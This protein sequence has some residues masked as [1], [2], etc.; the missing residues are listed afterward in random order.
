L[1]GGYGSFYDRL[2]GNEVYSMSGIP[3]LGYQPTVYYAPIS[4]LSAAQGLFGPTSFTQYAGKT[5]NPGSKSASLGI[6]HNFW[7]TL[8]DLA[9]QGTFGIERN[10]T[11]NINAIPLYADFAPQNL[12]TTQALSATTGQAPHLPTAIERSVYPGTGAVSI[13]TFNGFSAYNGLQLNVKRRLTKGLLWTAAY[14]WSHSFALNA[15]DPLVSSNLE[16]N[17]GPQGSDR[18]Q[19]LQLS[20]AY[21]LP[22]PGKLLG[23][24]P[25]GIITDGWNLSGITS[26]STG[27]PFTPGFSW[28]DGRDITGSPDEG[29][30]IN[31]VGNPYSNVPQGTPGLPHGE[32]WF[33][34]AAFA[35]PSIGSIGTA[36]VNIMYGPGYANFDMTID[37]KIN[38][39]S[40]KRRLE[41]KVEAFNV[42]NHVQFTGVNSSFTYSATTNQDTNANIG[43]LTGE[44]GARIMASEIRLVF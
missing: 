13:R 28:S 12:D 43:A 8:V 15:Y 31:V 18:R 6:Q 10:L 22:K 44:R 42:F 38:L 41:L 26:Y 32:I 35:S 34:P 5:P 9:Y 3:P 1:R 14:T 40:E 25:L 20:Y 16:R 11:D 4:S 19:V 37:R 7:G 33:N 29:A 17:W 23:L 30:R 39:H 24:K 21:D 2:D 27:A 36:G